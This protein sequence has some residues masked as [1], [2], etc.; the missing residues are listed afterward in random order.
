MRKLEDKKEQEMHPYRD[1]IAQKIAEK[2]IILQQII[3]HW[4]QQ[5]DRSSSVRQKKALLLIFCLVSSSYCSYLF[6]HALSG[7]A[8]MV[9]SIGHVPP[10]TKPP[11]AG[12]RQYSKNH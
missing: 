1:A 11:P 2:I 3:V 4:L 10:V 12:E 6:C 8:N 7:K 5:W 9:M